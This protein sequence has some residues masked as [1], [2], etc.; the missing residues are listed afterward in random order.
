[1]E[2]PKEPCKSGKYIR[3]PEYEIEILDN[4]TY[5]HPDCLDRFFET[6]EEYYNYRDEDKLPNK[7]HEWWYDTDLCSLQDLLNLAKNKDPKKI[8]IVLHRDRQIDHVKISIEHRTEVDCQAWQ[9]AYDAEEI[10]Y[11]QKYTEYIE[12]D[13]KYQLW[14]AEQELEKLVAKISGLKK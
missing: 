13:K 11:Q 5:V 12:A 2:K 7:V 14:L 10:E 3:M 9:A 1:M 4:N 8:M 6:E